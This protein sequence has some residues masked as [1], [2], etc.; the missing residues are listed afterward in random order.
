MIHPMVRK[1]RSGFSFGGAGFLSVQVCFIILAMEISLVNSLVRPGSR[2]GI[3][4]G[5]LAGL[6]TA[7]HLLRKEP[8]LDVTILDSSGPGMGGASSVAGGYVTVLVGF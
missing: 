1:A 8:S 4:G 6:S 7:F 3:V 2:V 5:G